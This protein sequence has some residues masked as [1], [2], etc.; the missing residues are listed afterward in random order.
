MLKIALPNT[1]Q[2]ISDGVTYAKGMYIFVTLSLRVLILKLRRAFSIL[3]LF[4]LIKE[5]SPSCLFYW[6][7]ILRS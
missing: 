5:S 7:L 3:L 4:C 6:A 2:T 1:F